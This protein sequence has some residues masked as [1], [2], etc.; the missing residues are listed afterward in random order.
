MSREAP[1]ETINVG[2]LTA[3]RVDASRF[4]PLAY[5]AGLRDVPQSE[6]NHSSYYR[7]PGSDNSLENDNCDFFTF[8]VD[9]DLQNMCVKSDNCIIVVFT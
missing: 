7:L 6:K 8:S 4:Y 9:G 1:L 5:F 3:Q 2:D